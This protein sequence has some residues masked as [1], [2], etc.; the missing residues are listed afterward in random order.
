MD[1]IQHHSYAAMQY[2]QYPHA[3]SSLGLRDCQR[4]MAP[5]VTDQNSNRDFHGDEV[6][7]VEDEEEDVRQ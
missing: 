2:L 7:S 4:R 3:N 5:Q 1:P 6:S